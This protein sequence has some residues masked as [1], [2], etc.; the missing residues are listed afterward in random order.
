MTDPFVVI[1][2]VKTYVTTAEK[3]AKDWQGKLIHFRDDFENGAW[4]EISRVETY[5]AEVDLFVGDVQVMCVA[6][7]LVLYRLSEESE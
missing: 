1:D 7:D 2:G 6:T 5:A 3:L 4:E